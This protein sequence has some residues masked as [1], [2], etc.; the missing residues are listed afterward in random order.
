MI[1]WYAFKTSQK[2]NQKLACF[3]SLFRFYKYSFSQLEDFYQAYTAE[4]FL[5][6]EKT[7]LRLSARIRQLKEIG[8]QYTLRG[9]KK[10]L[11]YFFDRRKRGFMNEIMKNIIEL[12]CVQLQLK[13]KHL[14]G[15]QKVMGSVHTGN[16]KNLS[17][18]KTFERVIVENETLN[19]V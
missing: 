19:G 1:L 4:H 16:R 7:F 18:R 8:I 15:N 3:R 13:A 5:Q 14:S 2:V 17:L 6:Y 9:K 12:R 11:C 10:H